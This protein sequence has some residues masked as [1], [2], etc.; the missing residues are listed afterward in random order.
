M[1]TF[2]QLQKK[3]HSFGL[4]LG[5][6]GGYYL[7]SGQVHGKHTQGRFTTLKGVAA[8]LSEGWKFDKVPVIKTM[9]Y[10]GKQYKVEIRSTKEP[11]YGLLYINDHYMTT[12]FPSI[13]RQALIQYI[14][15]YRRLTKP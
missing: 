11:P 3:A 6:N 5:E 2:K 9:T 14:Q 12:V 13:R 15:D 7:L 8:E 4:T 1:A 10:A